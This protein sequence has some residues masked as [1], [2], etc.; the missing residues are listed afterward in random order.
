MP[1]PQY[2]VGQTV[3]CAPLGKACTDPPD[4]RDVRRGEVV[5]R[6]LVL[7]MLELAGDVIEEE[8]EGA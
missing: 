6:R 8:P 5:E 4:E 3:R 7:G 1:V 2:T